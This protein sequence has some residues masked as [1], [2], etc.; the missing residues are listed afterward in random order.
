M[1]NESPSLALLINCISLAKGDCSFLFL[2]F[3]IFGL[4]NSPANCSLDI[5]SFLIAPPEVFLS[6]NL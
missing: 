2:N 1:K 3:L 6:K 4:C 5:V